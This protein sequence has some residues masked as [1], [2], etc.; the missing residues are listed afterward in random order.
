MNF[1]VNQSIC[2]HSIRIA[3]VSN[4]SVFQIGSAGMIRSLAQLYNTG[5]FTGKAPETVKPGETTNIV[6]P[7]A[8]SVPLNLGRKKNV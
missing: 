1:Y 6:D 5:G 4:S 3:S 8:P 7:E 2:I